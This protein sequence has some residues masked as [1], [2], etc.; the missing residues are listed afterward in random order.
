MSKL[1]GLP[2]HYADNVGCAEVVCS[3]V[4]SDKSFAYYGVYAKTI[5]PPFFG[6]FMI[7]I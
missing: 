3:Q 7:L 4:I 1:N 5:F 2:L 6:F